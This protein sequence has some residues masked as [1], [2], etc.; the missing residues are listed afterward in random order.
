MVPW[1]ECLSPPNLNVKILAPKV[2][3]LGVG[4]LEGE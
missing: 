4:P 3:V 2:M 1:S